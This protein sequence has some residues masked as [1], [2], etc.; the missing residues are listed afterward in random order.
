MN[1][2]FDQKRHQIGRAL[3]SAREDNRFTQSK[4]C[5]LMSDEIT[6]PKLSKIETGTDS[7]PAELIPHL[8]E[9]TGKNPEELLG[10]ES[11]SDTTIQNFEHTISFLSQAGELGIIGLEATRGTGLLRIVNF[12]RKMHVGEVA[13]TASSLRGLQQDRSN[14]FVRALRFL[15]NQ[16]RQVKIRI[17]FTHPL[18]G[19]DREIL[20]G[21]VAGSIVTEIFQ[22]IAWAMQFLNV[23]TEDIRLLKASPSVFSVFAWNESQGMGLINP[24]PTMAQGF[25]SFAVLLKSIDAHG[26]RMHHGISLFGSL[27]R[28]NFRDVWQDAEPTGTKK[29]CVDLDTG[30]QQ[31]L[32][33]KDDRLIRETEAFQKEDCWKKRNDKKQTNETEEVPFPSSSV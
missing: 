3:K 11:P 5:E 10:V 1:E 9:I 2:M 18:N 15:S 31:C 6:E 33:S 13:I 7:L 17:L 29:I 22:G 26:A 32:Q 23:R 12:L 19:Y 24:Y 27:Y 30:F 25:V 28:A 8:A 4:L 16:R 20:E 21:R 14:E